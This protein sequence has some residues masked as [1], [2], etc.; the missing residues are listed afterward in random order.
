VI[1]LVLSHIL[2]IIH[3]N[4]RELYSILIDLKLGFCLFLK[5]W[6]FNLSFRILLWI[7]FL[8]FDFRLRFLWYGGGDST[9]R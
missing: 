9:M 1:V 4:F 6:D 5:R 3:D 7:V 2:D 8:F